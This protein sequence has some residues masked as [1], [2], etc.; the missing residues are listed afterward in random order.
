MDTSIADSPYVCVV[1]NDY[2]RRFSGVLFC[3]GHDDI[4]L[5]KCCLA[6]YVYV[7]LLI[8]C[9]LKLNKNDIYI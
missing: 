9:E 7:V 2:N 1:A 4:G 8:F 6:Q 5:G 3:I